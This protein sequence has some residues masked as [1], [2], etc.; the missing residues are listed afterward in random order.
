MANECGDNQDNRQTSVYK[1]SGLQGITVELSKDSQKNT[2]ITNST[3][4]ETTFNI[5]PAIRLSFKAFKVVLETKNVTVWEKY[6]A[7]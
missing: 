5:K 1:L 2:F 3:E 4:R 7:I 6:A